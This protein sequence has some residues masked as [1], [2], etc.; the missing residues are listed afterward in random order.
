VYQSQGYELVSQ[1][2]TDA[3]WRKRLV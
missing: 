1:F 3:H 2:T